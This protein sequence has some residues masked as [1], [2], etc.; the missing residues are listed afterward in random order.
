MQQ[1]SDRVIHYTQTHTLEKAYNS[2]YII[3]Q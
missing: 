1:M 2:T 3:G